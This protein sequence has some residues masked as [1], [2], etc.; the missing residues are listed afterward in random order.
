MRISRLTI[1]K[2]G[3]RMYDRVSA[4]LAELIANTYDAD[5]EQVTISL[6]WGTWLAE[7]DGTDLGHRV[8]I[9]DN[10]HGMTTA[11]VNSQYL[12]VGGDRR[13]RLGTDR[14][15]SKSRPV[16]GRK[17]IGKLAPFGICQTI[18]VVTAGGE[19]SADG[20][21]VSHLVLRLDQVL[22]DIEDD[23]HPEP[24]P[25]DG[26]WAL[27]HGTT[28]T[29]S[30]FLRKRVP[31]G[32]EL[33][34]QLAA[35]FGLQQPDWTV[36]VVDSA[37][38]E[39]AAPAIPEPIAF[40]EAPADADG[41]SFVLGNLNIDVLDETRIEVDTRPV[42]LGDKHLPVSGWVGYTKR[43]YKDEAMAGVRIFARGKLIAQTRDFGI[44]AGFT[45]EFKLRSY[46][47]GAINAEWLDTTEDLVRSDRQD[48]IWSSEMGEALATW[49][50]TLMRELAGR[51]ED[52][53]RKQTWAEFAEVSQLAERLM[54]IAPRDPEFR[55]SVTDAARLLVSNKDRPAVS[56]PEHVER[57]V[58]LALS[59]G[60]HQSLLTALRD[61]AQDADTTL[62]AVVG[63]FERARVGEMYT[64]GQVAS[65]RIAAV[66]KLE[67]LVAEGGTLEASLQE[68]IEQQPWLL[69]P[70]WTPLGMNESLK[71]VRASFEA[72]YLKRTG[73][74]LV[75][76]AISRPRKEPDFVLLHEAGVLWIVEI[77]RM[78]YHLTSE[79]YDRGLGYLESLQT[80]L[81]ENAELHKQFPSVR[82]TFVV[83]H[84]N[85]LGPTHRSSLASD[86][87]IDQRTWHDLLD[88]TKRAHKDFLALV[89][90][91]QVGPVDETSGS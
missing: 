60:P 19:K 70:E 33:D 56:D 67:A 12:S 38:H 40:G 41:R 17:G 32:E 22:S 20:Y 27:N 7:A 25:L 47:V 21:A 73:Q 90:D 89:S 61:V 29:L 91:A 49:G 76:S 48:I 74:A 13:A 45:G 23:Y 75:T 50:Q 26:T 69:A 88:S 52:S 66:N 62:G 79:E 36:T 39:S 64:L 80:F 84:L 2:L 3:I 77:K 14:S 9:S 86:I 44:G 35:R 5:A 28:I 34:R 8:V 55:K 11:E 59:L 87:R 57:V 6:P 53:V 51:G 15:R 37:A 42:P 83:D 85:K 65:A 16:M 46:L 24:G 72:W 10:G 54:R 78:D 81:T 63:L 4:V 82:L 71:R 1:D 68:L 58:Q 43:P 18:D 31:T 30:N